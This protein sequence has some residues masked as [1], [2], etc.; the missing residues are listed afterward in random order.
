MYDKSLEAN[1][2]QLAREWCAKND[3]KPSEVSCGSEYK[4]K[5]KCP[6]QEHPVYEASVYNRTHLKSGCPVCAR[7]RTLLS[8]MKKG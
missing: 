8:R 6:N 7:E 3:K 5:W 2:P 1:Y 4:A